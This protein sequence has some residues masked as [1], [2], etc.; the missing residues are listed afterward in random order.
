MLIKTNGLKK[1]FGI[2]EA[3]VEALKNAS[4]SISAG[5]YVSI[6]GKS[7]SGKT[8]LMDILGLMSRPTDGEYFLEGSDVSLLED[9]EM[10]SIRNKKIGFVFQS[11]NLLPRATAL[12]NVELPMVY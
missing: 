8:T 7:G 9:N 10:A 12:E 11:F 4:F 5:E 2:G 1:V 6:I 3:R